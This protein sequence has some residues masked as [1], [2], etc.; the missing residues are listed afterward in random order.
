MQKKI[1]SLLFIFISLFL[2]ITNVFSQNTATNNQNQSVI[3]NDRN[4]LP[5][6]QNNG[7]TNE[8][9]NTYDSYTQILLQRN[10]DISPTSKKKQRH[11]IL[12]IQQQCFNGNLFIYNS[13]CG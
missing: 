9:P 3:L 11:D 5:L 1:T 8:I 2:V 12:R 7:G 4:G 10:S 13:G 6:A